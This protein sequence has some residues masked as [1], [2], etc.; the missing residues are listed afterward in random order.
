[1]ARS[2]ARA[3][4]REAALALVSAGLLLGAAAACAQDAGRGAQLY[5]QLPGS[6]GVGSCISCHGEPLNN[7]NSVLRG[8]AGGA[9]ISRTIAA[10]SAMGYLRQYLNDADLADIATY[11]ATVVPTA[12]LETLPEPWPTVD[13]FGVQAVG[14]QSAERTVWLRNLQ[15]RSEIAI[16]SVVSSDPATLPVQHE[17]PLSL[18]PLGSCRVRTWFRPAAVGPAEARFDVLEPG[19]QV[20]RSGRLLGTGAAL[21]PPTLA[22]LPATEL[23]DFG[24]VEVGRSAVMR[25][26]LHNPGGSAVTLTRLRSSGPQALRFAVAADCAAAGR[27]EPGARCDVTIAHTPR[28]AE[29]AESWVELASDAANAPLLRLQAIG[30][31]AAEPG[32]PASSPEQETPGGGAMAG[33]F[34]LGLALAALALRRAPARG[35]GESG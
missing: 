1:M 26:Q 16:G 3:W 6:P 29:R 13:D 34:V 17:C 28:S 11:L 4:S 24:R 8:A 10:V 33:W 2:I 14:T 5:R 23:V 32:P 12:A 20:L 9:I 19:G 22:W 27:I 35:R 30:V 21:Q 18:P 31:A 25:L 15:P 7:R